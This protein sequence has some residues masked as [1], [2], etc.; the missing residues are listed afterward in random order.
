MRWAP[1]APRALRCPLRFGGE[2]KPDPFPPSS[3]GGPTSVCVLG[4]FNAKYLPNVFMT[5]VW[6][7]F[8][9]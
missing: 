9:P 6:L 3:A 8:H 4:S 5:M 7:Q 1:R 2:R